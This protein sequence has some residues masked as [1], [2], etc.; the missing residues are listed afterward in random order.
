MTGP[1]KIKTTMTEIS[2]MTINEMC[3]KSN[4]YTD[5]E[6]FFRVLGLV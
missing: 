6:S 1:C 2:S 5:E 4:I 3:T